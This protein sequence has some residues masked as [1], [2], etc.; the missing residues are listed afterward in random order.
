[1]T[2]DRVCLLAGPAKATRVSIGERLSCLF[3]DCDVIIIGWR[4]AG[5]YGPRCRDA[6][7]R[8]APFLLVEDELARA[9]KT[10]S[11]AAL[12]HWWGVS[13]GVVWKWRKAFEITRAG[14]PGANALSRLQQG[15]K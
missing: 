6:E 2:D 3:R 15:Q 13:D 14:T 11:A 5:R 12:I 8:S 7:S 9:I 10:E 1:M 4:E